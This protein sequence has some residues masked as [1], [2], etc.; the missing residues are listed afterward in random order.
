M[1]KTIAVGKKKARSSTEEAEASKVAKTAIAAG[2]KNA[3]S[4]T[5]ETEVSKAAQ[6]RR[7]RKEKQVE[8]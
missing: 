5:E 8:A 1:A 2:K 3:S 6:I 4:S 7:I